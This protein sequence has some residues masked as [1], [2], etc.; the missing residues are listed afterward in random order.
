[1][2]W[3]RTDEL[4]LKRKQ[5]RV[6]SQII[7]VVA[8]LAKPGAL[9]PPS[10]ST[11][12]LH[13]RLAQSCFLPTTTLLETC[14]P[15]GGPCTLL[16]L[17]KT[18]SS[19]HQTTGRYSTRGSANGS[20]DRDMIAF[21]KEK[22]LQP[23]IDSSAGCHPSHERLS[24][25][26]PSRR[27]SSSFTTGRRAHTFSSTA[28]VGFAFLW[29]THGPK[30]VWLSRQYCCRASRARGST[31][32]ALKVSRISAQSRDRSD[33]HKGLLTSRQR[34]ASITAS[35]FEAGT[36]LACNRGPI[37]RSQPDSLRH[38]RDSSM[39]NDRRPRT[40]RSQQPDQQGV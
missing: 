33:I 17:P 22:S 34:K 14:R 20:S 12:Y 39:L 13:M 35:L 19:V 7:K 29:F 10:V 24:R 30:I 26:D 4:P 9:S 16:T 31:R 28:A 15:L 36:Q 2:R 40:I 3:H 6:L 27:L 32:K 5:P 23:P 21:L 11:L 37:L 1:M 38:G 8:P 25:A 18:R